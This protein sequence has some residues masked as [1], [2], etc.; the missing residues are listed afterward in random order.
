MDRYLNLFYSYAQGK[1]NR[2][3]ESILEN[4]ITR[5]FLIIL[6]EIPEFAFLLIKKFVPGVNFTKNDLYF[7]LQSLDD[8]SLLSNIVNKY[9]IGISL[10]PFRENNNLPDYYIKIIEN[11]NSKHLIDNL[12]K[13]FEEKDNYK[14]SII[15]KHFP[16]ISKYNYNESEVGE[17]ISDIVGGCILDGWIIQK[18]NFA[19][20][21][22]NKIRGN[23]YEEQM[24][25]HVLDKSGF[26]SNLKDVTIIYLL[27][28]DLINFTKNYKT[29][30]EKAIYLINEFL[31]Y[32][33]LTNILPPDFSIPLSYLD[34]DD[35]IKRKEHL[36][37]ISFKLANDIFIKHQI[38]FSINKHN[39]RE[40]EYYIGVDL[41]E[42]SLLKHKNKKNP[43]K[44][45]EN[46]IRN[47]FF[48]II[49]ISISLS[50][51]H[52]GET[53]LS[54]YGIFENASK[55]KQLRQI[56]NDNYTEI[57]NILNNLYDSTNGKLL[58][59]I[60]EKWIPKYRDG[61]Y[62]SNIR[63]I[64]SN[65]F[66]YTT[67]EIIT[68]I[69]E[70]YR[71]KDTV[72]ELKHKRDKNELNRLFEKSLTKLADHRRITLYKEHFENFLKYKNSTV[73]PT[74]S[75]NLE[76]DVNN[77]KNNLEE[78][79]AKALN[80]ILPLYKFLRDKMILSENKKK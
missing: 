26:N 49:H 45:T 40:G 29:T 47:D 54:V 3:N 19:L 52:E 42:R 7:D 4:N 58:Y 10:R 74:F 16:F 13:D 80:D 66:D 36:D 43:E 15:E 61:L 64:D 39:I 67:N 6:K 71:L 12:K 55:F 30:N 18:E 51:N 77:I 32:A 22:E 31:K 25:R 76:Y 63:V 38:K 35:M 79:I 60:T 1:Q 56:I 78:T 75:F 44:K 17:F 2:E 11:L 41:Y 48:S 24:I 68:K 14:K 62:I 33:E 65:F 5:A 69:D 34:S 46:K 59:K 8:K 50:L 9:L 53:V 20:A 57:K 72:L 73:N 21:I 70:I 37:D 27:W 28:A 23:L